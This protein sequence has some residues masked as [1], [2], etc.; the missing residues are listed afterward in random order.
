MSEASINISGRRLRCT[1]G[2]G[3][4]ALYGAFSTAADSSSP[5]PQGSTH[6]ARRLDPSD[7]RTRFDFRNRYQTPQTDGWR[8]T[9]T[10]RLDYALSKTFAFRAELPYVHYSPPT[11]GLHDDA[12]IGD[13]SLRASVRAIRTPSYALV[14]GT[15]F[16]F[17]TAASPRL[18]TGKYT[19]A[20]IAFWSIDAPRLHSTF[21]PN[22]QYFHSVGGDPSRP[23][24]HYSNAKLFVITRWPANFYT[25]TE[26]IVYVD[27]ERNNRV[28][29]TLEI[30]FGRFINQHIAVWLR[31]GIGSHGDDIPQV[32]RWNLELGLRYLF[33]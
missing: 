31:P 28:G 8:D 27:H 22:L 13:F 15:E 4:L 26:T 32:Y 33:D 9:F 14:V 10:T 5:P 29:A 24:V 12:G 30:E 21:F 18:G 16:F 7:F 2:A 1:L 11:P 6:V 17:D 19:V 3:L 25:G 23:D 20:P